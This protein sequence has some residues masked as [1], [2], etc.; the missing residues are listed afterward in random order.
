MVRFSFYLHSRVAVF[1]KHF[2]HIL[3][4]HVNNKWHDHTLALYF[5][6]DA[7]YPLILNQ[8]VIF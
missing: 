4:I 6:Q 7:N 5:V 3:Y 2:Q 1:N 8:S